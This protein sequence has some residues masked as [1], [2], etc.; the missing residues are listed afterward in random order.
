MVIRELDSFSKIMLIFTSTYYARTITV[1]RIL[2][3]FLLSCLFEGLK[4]AYMSILM[5]VIANNSAGDILQ[6]II[7]SSAQLRSVTAYRFM[8]LWWNAYD[9]D[10]AYYLNPFSI[11]FGMLI[12]EAFDC[13]AFCPI[14]CTC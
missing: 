1:C 14:T 13:G 5:I 10:I 3:V 4:I 8:K 6:H 11:F 9:S 12:M 2:S 7:R